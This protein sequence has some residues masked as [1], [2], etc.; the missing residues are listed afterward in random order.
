MVK[1]PPITIPSE[2]IGSIPRPANLIER[3][4]R[5]ESEDP[6]LVALYEDTLMYPAESIPDY[7]REQF[8]GR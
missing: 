8:R 6:N 5:G 2:P 1:F 7:S 4:S 3:V